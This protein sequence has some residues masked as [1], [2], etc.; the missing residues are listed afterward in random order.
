MC[1]VFD[2]VHHESVGSRIYF[3]LKVL[4]IQ[5]QFRSYKNQVNINL[6]VPRYEYFKF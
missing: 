4:Q 6:C 5:Q 1:V 2:E 3:L